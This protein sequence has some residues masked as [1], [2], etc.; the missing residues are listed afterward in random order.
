MTKEILFV[1]SPSFVEA[2]ERKV[3]ARGASFWMHAESELSAKHRLR[4][5]AGSSQPT[6]WRMSRR[7]EGEDMES[8]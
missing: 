5:A 3:Q 4:C 7:E 1:F 2:R 8:N 6:N